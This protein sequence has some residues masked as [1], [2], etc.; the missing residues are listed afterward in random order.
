LGHDQIDT[1]S[2][3]SSNGSY[4]YGFREQMLEEDRGSF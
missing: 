1:P 2:A 3:R 4:P